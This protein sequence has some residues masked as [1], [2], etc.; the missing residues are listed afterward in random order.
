MN[1]Y[2][3]VVML[4]QA[5]IMVQGF[6]SSEG[7]RGDTA[8]EYLAVE[9]VEQSYL[10]PEDIEGFGT[11]R[12]SLAAVLSKAIIVACIWCRPI[13]L[14]SIITICS[15]WDPLCIHAFFMYAGE[16]L[17]ALSIGVYVMSFARSR[18]VSYSLVCV[19]WVCLVCWWCSCARPAYG[20]PHNYLCRTIWQCLHQW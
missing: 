4:L 15:V 1:T 12:V 11:V 17:L 18:A 14:T 9:L 5:H 7:I 16:V 6:N 10:W 8:F 19:R 2:T 3:A 20:T 13:M